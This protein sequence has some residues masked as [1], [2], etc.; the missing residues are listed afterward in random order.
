MRP[1]SRISGIAGIPNR[2]GGSFGAQFQGLLR[3]GGRDT[4][5]LIVQQRTSIRNDYSR[6]IS[7]QGNHTVKMGGDILSFVDYDVRRGFQR[8]SAL[9]VPR[10]HQLELPRRGYGTAWAIPI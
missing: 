8:K 9:H 1:T 5:Q 10:R 4:E 6:F 7:W 2:D 3:I